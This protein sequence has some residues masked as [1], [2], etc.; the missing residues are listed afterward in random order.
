[1][2]PFEGL[3]D[4]PEQKADMGVVTVSAKR[5]G[6]ESQE[7][8]LPYKGVATFKVEGTILHGS[9]AF[10]RMLLRVPQRKKKKISKI[11]HN[12][13]FF[14]TCRHEQRPF[15]FESSGWGFQSTEEDQKGTS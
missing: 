5:T 3:C 14:Y 4:L 2:K 10:A 13:L 1:M 6:Y 11:V 9:L 12:R 7:N 8:S 15:W